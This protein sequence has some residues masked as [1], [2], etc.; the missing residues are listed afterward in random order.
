MSAIIAECR[1]WRDLVEADITN[2]MSKYTL[3]QCCPLWKT[4]DG[5]I[6]MY[7]Q[8]NPRIYLTG[9]M[10]LHPCGRTFQEAGRD[11]FTEDSGIWECNCKLCTQIKQHIAKRATMDNAQ[12]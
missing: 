1:T 10:W 5:P 2:K 11:D 7:L 8:E 3:K 9:G 12:T 6:E 4:L